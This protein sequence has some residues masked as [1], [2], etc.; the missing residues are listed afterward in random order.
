MCNL[1][2][3]LPFLELSELCKRNRNKPVIFSA[4]SSL[5]SWGVSRNSTWCAWRTTSELGSHQI[6]TSPEKDYDPKR[7]FGKPGNKQDSWYFPQKTTAFG[8]LSYL[9]PKKWR[10][11]DFKRKFWWTLVRKQKNKLTSVLSP[12]SRIYPQHPEAHPTRLLIGGQENDQLVSP[13]ALPINSYIL[14]QC[15]SPVFEEFFLGTHR[16]PRFATHQQQLLAKKTPKPNRP[17][18][19]GSNVN[20]QQYMRFVFPKW[21]FTAIWQKPPSP[22]DWAPDVSLQCAATWE[23]SGWRTPGGCVSEGQDHPN[24]RILWS[25]DIFRIYN[26][27]M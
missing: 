11:R 21:G 15:N 3:S 10:A 16:K 27:C 17:K 4:F 24:Q 23:A 25:N 22:A 7:E 20:L 18:K 5:G 1:Y 2:Q 8:C 26:L 14:A 13:F 12:S 19:T 9:D 6:N